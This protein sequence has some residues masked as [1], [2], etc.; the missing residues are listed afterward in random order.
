MVEQTVT[1]KI[2]QRRSQM[3]L[4]SF[5]YYRLDDAI[6][7]DDTWQ[8]WANE[9]AALQTAHPDLCRMGFYDAEFEGWNGDTGYH[10]PQDAAVGFRTMRLR[11]YH[12]MGIGFIPLT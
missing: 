4:H 12:E 9:L 2:R 1:E 5:I 11:G 8:R 7:S 10:L 3:L 6:V